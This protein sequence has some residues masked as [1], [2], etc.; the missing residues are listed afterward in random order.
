MA[1]G[2]QPPDAAERLTLLNALCGNSSPF[3]EDPTATQ[4]C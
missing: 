1:T 4:L 2:V 3:A